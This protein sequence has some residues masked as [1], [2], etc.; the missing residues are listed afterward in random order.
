MSIDLTE[1]GIQMFDNVVFFNNFFILAYIFFIMST[2]KKAYPYN[3]EMQT[4]IDLINQINTTNCL[5]LFY[6]IFFSY[7]TIIV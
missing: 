6:F 3:I 1:L 7:L 4:L 2:I 5:G